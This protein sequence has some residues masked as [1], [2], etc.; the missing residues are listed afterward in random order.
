[1]HGDVELL[2][3]AGLSLRVCVVCA[4]TFADGGFVLIG[5]CCLAGLVDAAVGRYVYCSAC[6]CMCS[7]TEKQKCII[8]RL[9][10]VTLL[11]IRHDCVKCVSNHMFLCI[12]MLMHFLSQSVSK[13]GV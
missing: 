6:V 13:D 1:M 2:S 8:Q 4:C 12:N 11:E 3:W 9:C 7:S 5:M 10:L